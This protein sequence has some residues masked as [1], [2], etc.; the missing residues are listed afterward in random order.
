MARH[1]PGRRRSIEI[2]GKLEHCSPETFPFS[3]GSDVKMPRRCDNG[4]AFLH[5]GC[6]RDESRARHMCSASFEGRAT[7]FANAGQSFFEVLTCENRLC[8]PQRHG[9]LLR[10]ALGQYVIGP[11]F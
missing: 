8:L 11:A 1:R 3:R 6:A 9:P 4:G 5:A 2:L 7:F 10:G